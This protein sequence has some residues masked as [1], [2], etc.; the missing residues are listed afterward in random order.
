MIRCKIIKAK[1]NYAEGRLLEVLEPHPQRTPPPLPLFWS[2][3]RVSIPA[4]GLQPP[5]QP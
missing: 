2:L 5:N 3:W 4:Y 1:K